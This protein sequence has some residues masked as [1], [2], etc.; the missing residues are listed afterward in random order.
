[1]RVHSQPQK[2]AKRGRCFILYVLLLYNN[3]YQGDIKGRNLV[4][5]EEMFEGTMVSLHKSNYTSACTY[6]HTAYHNINNNNAITILIRCWN[7]QLSCCCTQGIYLFIGHSNLDW[8]LSLQTSRLPMR[9]LLVWAK[10]NYSCNSL[11]QIHKLELLFILLL[12]C[13]SS[14]CHF[15]PLLFWLKN[16]PN[17]AALF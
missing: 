12:N 2:L 1:M 4:V 11:L 3:F 15:S 10:S 16:A 9:L 7:S 14:T 6:T 5:T 13:F 17:H 8:L